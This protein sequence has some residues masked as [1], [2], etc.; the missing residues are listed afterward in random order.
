[1]SG[2]Y[3]QKDYFNQEVSTMTNIGYKVVPYGYITYRSMS[4]TDF[5][6][7]NVQDIIKKGIVS[8][9]YPVFYSDST[10]IINYFLTYQMNNNFLFL[11]QIILSKEGGTRYALSYKK[12]SALKVY[13]PDIKEQSTISDFFKKLDLL[14]TIHQRKLEKLKNI[15]FTLLIKIK[16]FCK[17]IIKIRCYIFKK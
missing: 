1:M 8:P 13:I 9:A 10:K 3:L 2:I 17:V 12:L 14:V 16:L 4:D 7:F 11:K 6:R 15:K 5:F